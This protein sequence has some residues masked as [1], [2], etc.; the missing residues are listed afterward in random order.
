MLELLAV[1]EEHAEPTA[2]GIEPG[3][4]V[5]IAMI[6]VLLIM[7]WVRVPSIIARMLDARIAGIREQLDE[8][9]KLRAEAEALKAQYEAKAREADAEI[10]GLKSAAERHAHEIV[11][12]AEADAEALVARHQAMAEDK[13][14][15]AERAAVE[16]LRAKAAE[17]AAFAA[18]KLIQARHDEAA[19]RQLVDQAI[20]KI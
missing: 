2:F 18:R 19:D 15:A 4:Y 7:L 5:A 12:K 11:A 13:I 6:V 8:A 10:A 1:A 17:A 3:G 20:A 9:A 16:E 14:A